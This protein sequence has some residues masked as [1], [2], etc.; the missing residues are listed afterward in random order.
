[1]D[2]GGRRARPGHQTWRSVLPSAHSLYSPITGI[3]RLEGL[4][5][6]RGQLR[7]R[8]PGRLDHTVYL[9]ELAMNL[10]TAWIIERT[11][12]WPDC[13]KSVVDH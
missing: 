11:E 12:R 13:D 1:M 10:A 6:A 5:R 8:R 4:D 7:V 3:G 9:G 2:S